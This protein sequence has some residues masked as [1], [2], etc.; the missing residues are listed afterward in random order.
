MFDCFLGFGPIQISLM[1]KYGKLR[2]VYFPND[3]ETGES[4]ERDSK[5]PVMAVSWP[6]VRRCDAIKTSKITLC[7]HD[8]A[9]DMVISILLALSHTLYSFCR[10]NVIFPNCSTTWPR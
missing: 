10:C 3:V 1:E 4:I 6:R 2:H 7:E 8:S 9:C 5:R